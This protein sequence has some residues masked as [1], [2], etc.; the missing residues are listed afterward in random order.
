MNKIHLLGLSALLS[1]GACNTAKVAKQAEKDMRGD[2]EL[3]SVT[4]NSKG[5][6]INNLFNQASKKCFEGSSWHLVANNSSGFYELNSTENCP[7]GENKISWHMREE[8]G[9]PYFW[10]KQLNGEKAKNVR[11]G[12]KMRVVSITESNAV[13]S[14]E[15][16]VNGQK[17]TL[18]FNFS[19]K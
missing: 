5:L 14:Q 13:F 8:N 17:E 1:L 11:S 18:L 3:T 19:K 12:Y 16:P 7:S 2:W 15:I 10:F 4:T 6:T 9:V